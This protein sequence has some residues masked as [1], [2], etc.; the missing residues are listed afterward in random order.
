MTGSGA[1]PAMMAWL[2][3]KAGGLAVE[4]DLAHAVQA[5]ADTVIIPTATLRREGAEPVLI[6]AL[7]AAHNAALKPAAHAP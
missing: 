4:F 5:C 3:A 1:A 2:D 6:D 7:D